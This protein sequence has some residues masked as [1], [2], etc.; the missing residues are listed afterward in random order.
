MEAVGPASC[1]F[2]IAWDVVGHKILLNLFLAILINNFQ[3]QDVRVLCCAVLLCCAFAVMPCFAPVV[4]H[5]TGHAV[6][7]CAVHCA[8]LCSVFKCC[9]VQCHARLNHT[10]L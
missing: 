6:L 8:S 5:G 7:C 10:V 3:D 4:Y 9:I 1:L 2:W